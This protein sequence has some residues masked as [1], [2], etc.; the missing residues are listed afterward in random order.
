MSYLMTKAYQLWFG[1]KI[2]F[3]SEIYNHHFYIND[4]IWNAYGVDTILPAHANQDFYFYLISIHGL[5]YQQK[6]HIHPHHFHL[7][8]VH[9]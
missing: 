1:L 9:P 3:Q 6:I 4:M 5:F 2:I 7:I 8:M